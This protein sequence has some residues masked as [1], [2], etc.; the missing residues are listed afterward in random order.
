MRSSLTAVRWSC[1]RAPTLPRP[2]AR[3]NCGRAWGILRPMRRLAAA[4]L[5]LVLTDCAARRESLLYPPGP[6]GTPRRGGHAIFVREEDPDYLDPALSYGTYSA[7]IIEGVYRGLL[8][9]V[10]APGLEGARLVPELAET[11]P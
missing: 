7:P 6:G 5:L 11:L 4:L 10:D 9:Y 2:R 3:G 1:G 8:E